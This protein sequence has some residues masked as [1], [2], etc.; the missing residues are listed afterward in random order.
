MSES[1]ASAA[2]SPAPAPPAVSHAVPGR[3][4]ALDG[5]RGIAILL[6]LVMH[7]YTSAPGP[8]GMAI[9]PILQRAGSLGF[10]GVDLFFVLSGFLIGGI[11]LDHRSSPRLLPSFYAR[12]FFRI[13]PVYL[14]LLASY[15]LCRALP[16]FQGA[17]RGTYF[18]STVP[19]WSFFGM[20]QNVAMAWKRD[21]GPYWLGPTWS[22]AI[23]EQFY[24]VTPLLVQR[25]AP[26]ALKWFCLAVVVVSPL[27]RLNALVN[28]QNNLAAVFLL[29]TRADGLLCGV[30]CALLV[31]NEA[32]VGLVRQHRGLMRAL[33]AVLAAGFAVASW[34]NYPADSRPMILF[35]YSLLSIF[36][37]AILLHVVVFPDGHAA[38][39]MRFKPLT[40]IGVTS[41]F[42]YLFHVPIW[43]GLHWM[44]LHRPPLHY[45]W[46]AG[47][48]TALAVVVTF[49]AA[50]A[51]MRWFEGPL[52][53]IGR[54]FPYR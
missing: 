41:Y 6:V 38:R 25:F 8:Q 3:V 47:S 39:A 26:R 42:I 13:V 40:V 21:I 30:L 4:S 22:L 5:L 50:W 27:L 2:R 32:A 20:V 44:F 10:S 15:F 18:F 52:L 12:R 7:Y 43:Y 19:T 23:E 48:V 45:D 37:S 11:L 9:Y 33:I 34:Q 31:R 53:R 49:A 17:N 24:L 1:D 46:R 28:A 35:G 29:P 16:D 54:K 51:S 14:L 36:F